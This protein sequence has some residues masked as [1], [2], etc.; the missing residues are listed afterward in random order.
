M[1][2]NITISH[3]SIYDTPRAGI[4]ISEGT[5]GGHIIEH[6]DIFNTVKETGDHGS[7]NSWGRDRFWHPD[8]NI[9]AQIVC[10]H[11]A[12][13]LADIV[14]PIIIRHNRLRCDRGWDIV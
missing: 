5:W 1:C 6:N 7:I 12:L 8:Y 10:E 13:I 3:N 14:N 11:P 9:M 4:N 2:R